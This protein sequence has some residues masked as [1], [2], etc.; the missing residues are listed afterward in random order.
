MY[1]FISLKGKCISEKHYL[2]ANNI[3]NVFRVNTM[4]DYHDLY[5]TTD[6]L[7][8]ADVFEKFINTCLAYYG[9]DPCDCFSSPG[10]SWDAMLKITEIELD[11]ISYIDMHLFTEKGMRGGISYIA[12]RQ[13][14]ANNKY[15]KCYDS[16]KK[17]KHITYLDANN[18]YGSVMCQCFPCSRFKWLNETEI[19]DFCLNSISE[20]SSI[21]YVLKVDLEYPSKFDDFHNDYPLSPEKLE[22]SQNILSKYCSN[23]ANKYE[24]KIDGANKLVSNLGSKNNYVV[25]YKNLQ[26]YLSLGMKLT[27][28]HRILGLN[29]SDWFKKYVDFN[30]DKRNNAVNSFET[31]FLKLMYNSVFGKTME[32]LRKTISAKLINNAKDY[33]K[34]ISKPIFISQNIFSKT[35]VTFHKIKPV[36]ILNKKI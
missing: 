30:T 8:L 5:L 23:I 1:V 22:I 14:G 35:C 15:M 24:I 25:H 27:K 18:L 26:L 7:L 10:L 13:S 2:K 19:S 20:N 32:N 36:L 28:V 3:W 17:S 16:S 31:D 34:C 6:V 29:Q 11:L 4:G 9:L 12:K 33:V 21:G